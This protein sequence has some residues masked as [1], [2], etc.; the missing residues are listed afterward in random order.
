M[1]IIVFTSCLLEFGEVNCDAS[2]IELNLLEIRSKRQIKNVSLIQKRKL[3]YFI[4][5]CYTITIVLIHTYTTLRKHKIVAYT[6][7]SVYHGYDCYYK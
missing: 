3:K 5:K 7:S 2:T 1:F 4:L 6:F